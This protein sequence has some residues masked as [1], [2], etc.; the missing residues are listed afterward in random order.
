MS[1]NHPQ[2][3]PPPQS[4]EKLSSMKLIP[5]AKKFGDHWPKILQLSHHR[6]F[7]RG[8]QRLSKENLEGMVQL[9]SLQICQILN[10]RL[11]ILYLR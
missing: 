4:M 7:L 5:G 2:T 8:C 9:W 1:L 6:P 11:H 3:V 10:K